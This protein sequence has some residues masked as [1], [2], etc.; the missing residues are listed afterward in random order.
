MGKSWLTSGNAYGL[1]D[2]STYIKHHESLEPFV[3]GGRCWRLEDS[4]ETMGGLTITTRFDPRGGIERDTVRA[5]PP[6]E[7]SGTLVATGIW[8]NGCSVREWIETHGR[9]GKRSRA[10]ATQSS[11]SEA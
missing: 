4:S 7:T 5:E 1:Q 9:D 6:G 3:W 2:G 11:T 10:I 8:T